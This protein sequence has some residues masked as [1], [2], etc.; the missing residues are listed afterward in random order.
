MRGGSAEAGMG[1]SCLGDG[2]AF[3]GRGVLISLLDESPKPVSLASSV[4]MPQCH[5]AMG[6]HGRLDSP[7]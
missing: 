2:M 3:W 5:T 4:I 1:T 6:V 7:I